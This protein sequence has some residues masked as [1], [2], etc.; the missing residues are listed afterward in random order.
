M[1]S[2]RALLGT[3]AAAVAAAG[4]AVYGDHTHELDDLARNVGIEPRPLP[5]ESDQLLIKKVQRDHSAV[6]LWTKA[7]AARQPG[8]VKTLDPLVA[9]LQAQIEHLGGV[10]ANLDVAAP[11]SAATAALDSTITRYEDAAAL[12]AKQALHAASAEFAQILASIA[13]S[14]SQGVL[15]LRNARKALA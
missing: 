12:R 8:L 10:A 1:I 7:V 14:L 15:L 4:A 13:V 2:R 5:V 11:P 3:G 9:N 6:L